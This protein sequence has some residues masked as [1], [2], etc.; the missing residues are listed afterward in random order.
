M[1][2][3]TS[4]IKNTVSISQFN[5]GLAGKVFQE[6]R[7]SGAKIVIKN[8]EPECVL[9]SPEEYVRLMDEVND[10]RLLE[11]A[12]ARMQNYDPKTAIPAEEEVYRDLGITEEDLAGSDEVEIE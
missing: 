10:A 9:L 6:V 2:D 1:A 7:K 5:R 11:I 12:V 3:L 4:A 8:N